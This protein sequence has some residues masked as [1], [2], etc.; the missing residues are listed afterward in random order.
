MEFLN[1][2]Y[3]SLFCFFLNFWF[4]MLNFMAGNWFFFMLCSACAMLC[5]RNYMIQ[6]DRQ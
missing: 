2:R 4:A 5:A 1:H 3:F 6:K